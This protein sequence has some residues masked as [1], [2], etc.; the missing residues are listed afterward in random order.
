[1]VA[2]TAQAVDP[3]TLVSHSPSHYPGPNSINIALNAP[4][5]LTFNGPVKSDQPNLLT[6]DTGGNA[7]ITLTPSTGQGGFP[8][9]LSASFSADK[10]TIT[11]T[12]SIPFDEQTFYI[13]RIEGL[14]SNDEAAA[15]S[16]PPGTLV[17]VSGGSV[18]PFT[19]RTL[20]TRPPFIVSH[21]PINNDNATVAGGAL[22]ADADLRVQ[23][24]E[25]MVP[26]TVAAGTTII[27]TTFDGRTVDMKPN[28]NF[29]FDSTG[30]QLTISLKRNSSDNSI[31]VPW[32]PSKSAD[33]ATR[34][35]VTVGGTDL[36]GLALTS[37][38]DGVN[39]TNRNPWTFR[40]EDKLPPGLVSSSPSQ[41]VTNVT[42]SAPVVLRFDEPIDCSNTNFKTQSDLQNIG[43]TPLDATV[44]IYQVNGD[45]DA[46]DV[47]PGTVTATC[48]DN[49]RTVT[50][51]H[52]FIFSSQQGY[53]VRILGTDDAASDQFALRDTNATPNLLK[54]N[55]TITFGTRETI[56]PTVAAANPKNNQGILANGSTDTNNDNRV[57]PTA[58]IV[59]TFSEPIDVG[60]FK[61]QLRKF[62]PTKAESDWPLIPTT[63]SWS[64]SN[65]TVTIQP[66]APLEAG[67]ASI[68]KLRLGGTADTNVQD[69]SG[70][71]LV[72]GSVVPSTGVITSVVLTFATKDLTGP[73]INAL[74]PPNGAQID[75]GTLQV[76]PPATP[77]NP[78]GAIVITLTE[79][80]KSDTAANLPVVAIRYARAQG[81][82]R[83]VP[84]LPLLA[85][86][87]NQITR[88]PATNPFGS[89]GQT[90]TQI[91]YQIKASAI[92]ADKKTI[93]LHFQ[94]FMEFCSDGGICDVGT[95]PRNTDAD[96][97]NNV[98]AIT[99]PGGDAFAFAP[100]ETAITQVT[101]AFDLFGNPIRITTTP[102]PNPFIYTIIDVRPPQVTRIRVNF[103]DV[104]VN[105]QTSAGLPNP[106]PGGLTLKDI[107]PLVAL[108]SPIEITFSKPMGTSAPTT[109]APTAPDAR[110]KFT[111]DGNFCDSA[112]L[113]TGP[114]GGLSG[115]TN[116]DG[117]VSCSEIPGSF[118]AS[119]LHS[120]RARPGANSL[121]STYSADLR[122]VTLTHATY[123][124]K[125]PADTN[126]M[127]RPAGDF[128]QHT[129]TI[130]NA[131]DLQGN[132]IVSGGV[133]RVSPNLDFKA[134]DATTT[135][136]VFNFIT[137]SAPRITDIQ[138]EVP[139]DKDNVV[140]PTNDI[141][142]G[143]DGLL[144]PDFT[145]RQWVSFAGNPVTDE[146]GAPIALKG[147]RPMPV[148][149]T[150]NNFI[151]RVPLNS[152]FRFIMNSQMN[153]G[154]VAP[155][156]FTSAPQPLTGWGATWNAK[157]SRVIWDHSNLLVGQNQA[158]TRIPGTATS[159]DRYAPND[160]IYEAMTLAS[161][162]DVKGDAFVATGGA[163]FP[164]ANV[165][166]ID[167]TPPA[168]VTVEYLS[169]LSNDA[170]QLCVNG[171]K[172]G[173]DPAKAVWKPLNGATDVPSNTRFRVRM[174]ETFG[175]GGTFSANSIAFKLTPEGTGNPPLAF[176]T[177]PGPGG[178]DVTKLKGTDFNGRPTNFVTEG[179]G[180]NNATTAN[181]GARQDYKVGDVTTPGG[182]TLF[183]LPLVGGTSGNADNPQK[184]AAYSLRFTGGDTRLDDDGSAANGLGPA[185]TGEFGQLPAN[186]DVGLFG[187]PVIPQVP[188]NQIQV[189]ANFTV[190][191]AL[192]PTTR[193]ITA[194][195]SIATANP[196]SPIVVQFDEP[197]DINT[198]TL[199][200]VKIPTTSTPVPTFTKAY[201][202]NGS[203]KTTVVFT[204][205]APLVKPV[206]GAPNVYGFQVQAGVQDI[207]TTTNATCNG[208]N[209][210]NSLAALNLG[211]GGGFTVTVPAD[212]TPPA[213]RSL[214]ATREEL[215]IQYNKPVIAD[216][217]NANNNF[218]V[219]AVNPNNYIARKK[220]EIGDTPWPSDAANAPFK[221]CADAG[222]STSNP[223]VT[224]TETGGT[225]QL[226][227][228]RGYINYSYFD[229]NRT[230]IVNGQTVLSPGYVT[231]NK[232]I[233]DIRYNADAT[234][235]DITL[236]SPLTE[237]QGTTQREFIQLFIP[238]GAIQD[239]NTNKIA[240]TSL[241]ATVQNGRAD[242]VV[243]MS[244]SS[245]VPGASPDANN[246]F[247]V[248]GIAGVD[249]SGSGGSAPASDGL[250]QP[251]IDIPEP[252]AP[253]ANHVFAFSARGANEPGFAGQGGNFAQELQSRPLL[254]EK[255]V[256]PRVSVTSDLGATGAPATITLTW[257][258]NVSGKEVPGTYAVEL[259]NLAPK[260]GE[261]TS[262]DMRAQ[263]SFSYTVENNGLDQTR[264]FR[265]EVTAPGVQ[266]A[267]FQLSDG[268]NLVAVPVRSQ[269][270]LVGNVFFG[271]SPLVVYRYDPNSGY[272]IFPSSPNF[273]N[274]E[275][276]RGYWLRPRTAGYQ[277]KVL[278]V[279][280][281][282]QT[283]LS[284]KKGWNLI[285]DPFL[286]PVNGANMQVKSG[287][288][289]LSV[290]DA[291][292]RGLLQDS[293]VTF[294]PTTHGYTNPQPLS[295]GTLQP[296]RGYWVLAF[297]DIG[298]VMN[299]PPQPTQ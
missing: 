297:S 261:P 205:T 246:F 177:V 244:A 251:E 134:A 183:T 226:Q 230:Q 10:K 296:W 70:N 1:M 74:A 253:G 250:D 124:E 95:D 141:D 292:R 271:L 293:F 27:A 270:P 206:S 281:I 35:T 151:A 126:V 266:Q 121:G 235:V 11:I 278:G 203:D 227:S 61:V 213:V 44:L 47:P 200:T 88:N 59:L 234:G 282:G 46:T 105:N 223:P 272:E 73:A 13:V 82:T 147:T 249:G 107:Y 39:D 29:V 182:Q 156:Q 86:A 164:K 92:S 276:G 243:Q 245:N 71:K 138:F 114:T 78:T 258:L 38:P 233:K 104:N 40:T 20:D 64:N 204:P 108:T 269:N 273:T 34:I 160:S 49:N 7:K 162:V 142:V 159:A 179:G 57:S 30:A 265:L 50:L 52:S 178:A 110:L 218:G 152:R 145:R 257:N 189:V 144:D 113:L 125:N 18:N 65:Q 85:Q 8:L 118:D 290:A 69:L 55:I 193:T 171:A 263:N 274:V 3:L 221:Q 222:T 201:G 143:P 89:F 36:V 77:T 81:D 299:R 99:P 148:N 176:E 62:D 133:V 184:P 161:G 12:H 112:D 285:A 172:V 196:D 4:I 17:P 94:K 72:G 198:V 248:R 24:N 130:V 214:T 137:T 262:I 129:F 283:T 295:T 180:A 87:D 149:T 54:A 188:G 173:F 115:D 241:E 268:F 192:A 232:K 122:T 91:L 169:N 190:V 53:A 252:L 242:W 165:N 240:E 117:V 224:C 217:D 6:T 116:A 120:W 277:L 289:T 66:T 79:A 90:A 166:P 260:A 127:D 255:K 135:N 128:T 194:T 220:P 100:G 247:G 139:F 275:V 60:S 215:T 42:G 298:L 26:D 229:P 186:I 48:S 2:G 23:F 267:P 96:P 287:A 21:T 288:D 75:P 208:P 67:D 155:P 41:G 219:S 119:A 284:L 294:D 9:D 238:A 83:P 175:P 5:V 157:S 211:N 168:T 101:Q 216:R 154:T 256:W 209:T 31:I 291:V 158:Y 45:L 63:V 231:V 259:I 28:V 150:G 170:G 68:Y 76:P 32:P 84:P 280:N 212:T 199:K 103:Q 153:Q 146:S 202:G 195:P 106:N 19:F 37:N 22:A 111:A 239:L 123:A 93:T 136:G 185:D 33:Q 236:D 15:I 51:D 140:V 80:I 210:Q 43:R 132:S 191:D 225:R 279:P 109:A 174:N 264:F 181:P 207:V 98:T 187:N 14:Q 56:P 163:V 167:V 197:V 131:Q 25:P 228:G 58:P 254:N 237:G 97:N 16:T 286:Q 102:A